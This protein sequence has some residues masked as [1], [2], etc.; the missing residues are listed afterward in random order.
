MNEMKGIDLVWTSLFVGILCILFLPILGD[1]GPTLF[2]LGRDLIFKM[3]VELLLVLYLILVYLDRSY[4]PKITPILVSLAV[5][6]L[7]STL[8]TIFSVQPVFS[9]FGNLFRGHGLLSWLHLFVFFVILTN[10]VRRKDEW[11]VVL[12]WTVIVSILVCCVGT[13]EKVLGSADRITSTLNNPLF[14]GAYI[15]IVLFLTLGTL[16]ESKNHHRGWLSALVL[17]QLATIWW[18]KSQ[19][20]FVGLI[21]GIATFLLL[22]LWR[23]LNGRQKIWFISLGIVVVLLVLF[24][25]RVQISSLFDIFITPF[26]ELSGD[27]KSIK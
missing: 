2:P 26:N 24:L 4:A 10:V 7:I 3:M 1:Y 25:L 22:I 17:L 23:Q 19:G 21:L 27:T 20:V 6:I 18:T 5:F 13:Y 11:K 12:W 9:L 16:L 15:L 14:L 8:A